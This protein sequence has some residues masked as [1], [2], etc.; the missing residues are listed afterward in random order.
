METNDL[1]VFIDKQK[2]QT[3]KFVASRANLAQ[4]LKVN[5]DLIATDNHFKPS[6]LMQ[7]H[8]Q[9]AKRNMLYVDVQE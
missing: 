6:T 2:C 1:P 9:R 5:K 7:F 3:I 8:Q 4:Q